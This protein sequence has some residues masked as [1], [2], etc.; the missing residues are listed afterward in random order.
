MH[1][2][3]H[4]IP[5]IYLQI[6]HLHINSCTG[7]PILCR[8]F[9]INDPIRCSLDLTHPVHQA[10]CLIRVVKCRKVHVASSFYGSRVID[11]GGEQEGTIVFLAKDEQGEVIFYG[12]S[13]LQDK[14][15]TVIYLT[16]WLRARVFCEPSWLSFIEDEGEYCNCFGRDS[17]GM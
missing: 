9:L 3:H 4:S 10:V 8:A 6:I 7:S 17:K 12:R 15:D 16:F 11:G 5:V 2:T 1:L 13:Y 14:F